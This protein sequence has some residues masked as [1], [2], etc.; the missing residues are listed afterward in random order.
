MY[1]DFIHTLLASE[2]SITFRTKTVLVAYIIK[3]YC[4]SLIDEDETKRLN[5]CFEKITSVRNYAAHK[6]WSFDENGMVYLKKITTDGIKNSMEKKYFDYS[7]GGL[8]AEFAA[9]AADAS[10]IMDKYFKKENTLS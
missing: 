1:E 4:T 10:I 5:K 7:K 6:P 2:F 3:K 9:C 8:I